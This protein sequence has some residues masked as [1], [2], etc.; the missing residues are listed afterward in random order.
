M[1]RTHMSRYVL[2]VALMVLLLATETMAYTIGFGNLGGDNLDRF[3]SYEEHGYRVTATGG[4]WFV[5]KIFGN[6]IPAIVAGP[7]YHP[8]ESQ[9]TVTEGGGQFTFQ[10]LDLTN[11]VAGET[12]YTIAGFLGGVEVLSTSVVISSINTFETFNTS[13]SDS[14]KLVDRLTITGTPG[15][16]TT[17]FNIDN[18]RA[19]D[20]PPSCQDPN[21]SC[22]SVPE[23][24]SMLLLGAGLAGI[25]IWRRRRGLG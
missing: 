9:I 3:T 17:S 7:I 12:S 19:G 6:E 15:S 5:A 10:G 14:L 24:A 2:L 16:R 20:P 22:S 13:L 8:G 1:M 23:P 21:S 4:D 25:E 11:N 18:I